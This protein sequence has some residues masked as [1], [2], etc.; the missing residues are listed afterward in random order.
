MLF[1]IFL[2]E[3]MSVR[4]TVTALVSKCSR[5]VVV[6]GEQEFMNRSSRVSGFL[7]RARPNLSVHYRVTSG[8]SH[9]QAGCGRPALEQ[10]EGRDFRQT[11]SVH[12][13]VWSKVANHL[14]RSGRR[15]L[16]QHYPWYR[17]SSS[18]ISTKFSAQAVTKNSNFTPETLHAIN[19]YRGV[20]V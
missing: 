2:A 5:I 14:Q 11:H 4:K 8:S 16:R 19:C 9:Y 7:L 6:T 13:G 15:R 17:V 10:I 12:G 1:T 3:E 20:R 18:G